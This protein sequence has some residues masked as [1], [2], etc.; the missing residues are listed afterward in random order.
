ML[1]SL[2]RNFLNSLWLIFE[3]TCDSKRINEATGNVK[4]GPLRE[5]KPPLKRTPLNGSIQF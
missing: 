4:T 5:V 3:N 2:N 1:R